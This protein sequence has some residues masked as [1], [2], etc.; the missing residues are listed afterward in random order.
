MVANSNPNYYRDKDDLINEIESFIKEYQ[1]EFKR[2]STK[3][4]S[5]FEMACYNYIVQYYKSLKFRLD[6][7][8]LERESNVFL[9]KIGTSGDPDKYSYFSASK[10]FWKKK[11]IEYRI[12]I[13]QNFPVQSKHDENIY[14]T[15]DIVIC[16]NPANIVR[17]RRPEYYDNTRLYSYLPNSSLI[18]FAES[19][20]YKPFPELI[21]NYIGIINELKPDYLVRPISSQQPFHI[22]PSLMMS[23][24][25]NPSAERIKKSLQSRYKINIFFGLF[26]RP[27]Q[28]YSKKAR[29]LIICL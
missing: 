29:S 21:F 6:I 2:H 8:N 22:A 3:M 25:G 1:A 9:Y 27:S 24:K 15:P 26:S 17:I 28:V 13:R 20:N 4:S 12:E 19:K 7:Q 16:R 23:M 5:Y 11:S 10:N 18:S 14:L